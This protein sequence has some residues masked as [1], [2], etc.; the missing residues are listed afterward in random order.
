MNIKVTVVPSDS[1]ISVNG[2]PLFFSFACA[3]NLHALQWTNNSGNIEF[4]DETENKILKGADYTI[5]VLPF[6]KLWQAEKTRLEIANV[7]NIP[8]LED[9]RIEKITEINKGYSA[10]MAYIQAGY[11]P[12]E[13]LSWERQ[14]SQARELLANPEAEAIFVR[15]LA[16]QKNISVNEMRDRILR[17]A[18][19]WEPIAALL[20]AQRQILEEATLTA[21]NTEQIAGVRVSY[22][23]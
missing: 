3:D 7:P 9:L 6:V 2:E 5:E 4:I 13:I 10:V 1:F 12:E 22:S 8:T 11:P 17:N 19:N 14:A 16:S 15:V 21:Q 23:V 20:T 18:T